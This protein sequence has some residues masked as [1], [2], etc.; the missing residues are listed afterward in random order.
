[1]SKQLLVSTV[2]Y[3]GIALLSAF[4]GLLACRIGKKRALKKAGNDVAYSVNNKVYLPLYVL[5]AVIIAAALIFTDKGVDRTTYIS[6]FQTV[7]LDKVKDVQNQE[8]G[9]MFINYALKEIFGTNRYIPLI[10]FY[11][12]MVFNSYYV[13]Y[14]LRSRCNIPFAIFIFFTLYCVQ[15]INLMRIYVA[16]SIL[17]VASYELLRRRRVRSMIFWLFAISIHYSS[18]L[19]FL[20]Y[21]IEF[22]YNVLHDRYKVKTIVLLTVLALI[23]ILSIFILPHLSNLPVI[24]RYKDYMVNISFK[25]IGFYQPLLYLPLIILSIYFVKFYGNDG[26]ENI[27]IS[28]LITCFLYAMVSYMISILGRS[29]ALFMYPFIVGIPYMFKFVNE[30][31]KQCEKDNTLLYKGEHILI[32]QIIVVCLVVYV[33]IKFFIYMSG[34]I[35]LDGIGIS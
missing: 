11:G 2:Y 10:F 5:S 35:E 13:I 34:Y 9:F 31:N 17:L 6:L 22:Y 21:I 14:K 1:M 30:R 32:N 8:P 15:S 23:Y 4:V 12:L 20:V 33:I 26:H 7:T 28:N 27:Y 16:G 3:L 25:Q 19:F 24:E 29:A 18:A